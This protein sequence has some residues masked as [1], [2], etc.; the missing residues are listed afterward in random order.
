MTNDPLEA[1][2]A[3]W[4][5]ILGSLFPWLRAEVDPMTKARGRLVTA[6]DAI[7]LEGFVPERPWDLGRPAEDRR[8]LAR[9]LVAKALLEARWLTEDRGRA[10]GHIL[11]ILTIVAAIV[12]MALSKGQMDP[13][14]EP[15]GA[16][17]VSYWTASKLALQGQAA[18]VY[19]IPT[20]WNLQKS[21]FGQNLGYT[22]FF[23]PPFFLLVCLPFASLPYLWSLAVWLIITGAAYVRVIQ[24]YLGPR[25]GIWPILAFPAILL[26]A[27]HGQNGFL[28]AALIGGGSLLLNK[29]PALAGI[30]FGMTACKPQLA[31]MV[32]VA[33]LA[34][35]RWK[36]IGFAALTVACFA[37]L[38]LAI[39]GVDPW[40]G[41]LH[42]SPL[43][44]VALEQN[45]VGN[46]KMQSLF[47]AVRLWG[48]G[49]WLAYSAQ[50]VLIVVVS[51]TLFYLQKRAFRSDAEGPALV[52][53]V[54]LATPFILDYDLTLLAIP[55]AWLARRALVN[56]FLPGEKL[57]LALAYVLPLYARTLAGKTG[58][59]ATPF[60]ILAVFAY[61]VIRGLREAAAKESSIGETL[62]TAWT[63]VERKSLEAEA[64]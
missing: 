34:A 36:T 48:G 17:F 62:T 14:G 60:L 16:D 44:R 50:C 5:H 23:Y 31:I 49:L 47:A 21:L 15:L 54:L 59:P 33:M 42:N 27:G 13:R 46:E 6:L 53:S 40:R 19:D 22:A 43:A 58:V 39:W 55:I 61:V 56:G 1:S 24:A 4:G 63:E 29:R 26:N 38:T 32:P 2:K 20:H 37:S 9:V 18:S 30:C 28:N 41:F 52:S 57:V 7:G 64:Y 35:R 12:W 51:A 10:F 8:A 11:L 25:C 45:W 3:R